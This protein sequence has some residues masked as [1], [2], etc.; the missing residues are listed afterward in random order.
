MRSANW[1][2]A[3]LLL[4]F[5]ASLV[6][7]HPQSAEPLPIA[8]YPVA[9]ALVASGVLVLTG[10]LFALTAALVSGVLTMAVA[11]AA[12]LTKRPLVAMPAITLLIGA[13]VTLRMLLARSMARSAHERSL[14]RRHHDDAGGPSPAE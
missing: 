7:F 8:T 10:R 3:V 12:L 9:G 13:M 4:V 1:S 11:L 2:L 5:G 6:Y 14:H